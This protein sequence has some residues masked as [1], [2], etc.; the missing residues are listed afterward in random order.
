MRYLLDTNI[1]L[2]LLHRVDP[3]HQSVLDAMRKLTSRGHVLLCAR[4]NV[5][6]FW[7]VC[8]RP[9]SARGGLNLSVADTA[10]RLR[11]LERLV[12]VLNEPESTYR[13]WKQLVTHHRV[14]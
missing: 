4:Q 14:S 7:N 12:Q 10:R 9:A 3:E 8:T 2:R 11:V 1:L 6:E 13:R 5:I